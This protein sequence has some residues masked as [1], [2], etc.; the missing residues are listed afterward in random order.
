MNK[1]TRLIVSLLF[2]VLII[3][4][5][6][7]TRF[8]LNV[9]K[10]PAVN[11][12][13]DNIEE[14]IETNHEG[15]SIFMDSSKNYGIAQSGRISAVAEWESLEFAGDYRCIALKKIDGTLK[16]GCIDFDGNVIVPFIYNKIEKNS[17][18]NNDFYCAR[19]ESDDSFVIYNSDFSPLF[20]TPW[21][22]CEF[23]ADELNLTD[24]YGSYS[25]TMGKDGLLFKSARLSGSIANLPYELNI[26]SR[27]LLSK[28][29]PVMIE[30]M[31]NFTE[32]YIENA[33]G[34]KD[35]GFETAENK[36]KI[37]S[38]VYPD[39]SEIKS[40]K[41]VAVPEVHIYTTGSENGVALYEASVSVQVE[42]EYT[43]ENDHIQRFTDTVKGA[44]KFS[45]NFET[46]LTAISGCFEPDTPTYPRI[47]KST[48][49]TTENI[50]NLE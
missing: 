18:G 16:F 1:R 29:T 19:A 23:T 31:M 47:E 25:Y 11:G 36:A 2:V 5:V 42:I 34:D 15:Y 50:E 10:D 6:A 39:S 44:V 33:F 46:D 17:L 8:Y 26:Y 22:S 3:L 40:K 14:I 20:S 35:S 38:P 41:P 12:G 43:D 32:S 4:A 21:K 48:E 13:S 27:V 30:Q 24:N 49:I 9:P 28:L 7:I 45:G 37:F